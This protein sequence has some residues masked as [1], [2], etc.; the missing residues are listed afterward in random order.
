[1]QRNNVLPH[2]MVSKCVCVIILIYKHVGKKNF[3]ASKCQ[4]AI[5]ITTV[6]RVKAYKIGDKIYLC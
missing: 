2:V 3:Q 6:K 4:L 1:M 5:P